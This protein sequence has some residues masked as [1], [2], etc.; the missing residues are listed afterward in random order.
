MEIFSKLIA[1]EWF[2][3]PMFGMC[4]FVI[5][6]LWIEQIYDFLKKKSLGKREEIISIL[7][8][9]GIDIDQKKLT[10][11]LLLMS[12]GL[13]GL[14]FLLLW[15]NIIA[16]ILFSTSIIIAGWS[17]PLLI[18]KSMYSSRC[19][20][21][22]GQMVDGLTIMANGISAG[23]NPQE[24]MKRVVEIMK[25]PMRYEFNKV[26]AQMQV[27]D[28]FENALNDLGTRIPRPDVQMFVTSIN[29]LK[30]TGGNLAETFQTIVST[31]RERQKI[32]KKIEAMTAQGLMQGIIVT[33]IPFVLCIV[34]FVVDPAFISPMFNTTL[35]WV[36][37][38]MMLGLQIIGGVI[39]KKVVTIKV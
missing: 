16:G 1:K 35:G 29:I 17:L 14:I 3:I 15:P 19:S 22:V 38:A 12:F 21:F 13:G 37:L 34:F 39:I 5:V 28:S 2:M 33:M 18:V 23:S 9:M 4:V 27:G 6:Y 26:L 30:E 11:T 10:I 36:M 20:K 8:I 24:S 25:N 7:K 31:I 32:E